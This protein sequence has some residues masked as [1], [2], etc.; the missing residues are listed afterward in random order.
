MSQAAGT[1]SWRCGPDAL[2]RALDEFR[3]FGGAVSG[4]E[5]GG[6]LRTSTPLGSLEGSYQFDGEVL[7]VVIASKPA[8]IPYEMIWNRLDQICGPPIMIA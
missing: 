1:R 2:R 3:R 8:M 4:G 6:G 5:S 7:T